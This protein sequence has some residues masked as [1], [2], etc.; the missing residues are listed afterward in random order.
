[1]LP[2]CVLGHRRHID[3]ERQWINP[4][5][6][7]EPTPH[8]LGLTDGS[9]F[10]HVSFPKS[11]YTIYNPQSRTPHFP[12]PPPSLFPSSNLFIFHT[13]PLLKKTSLRPFHFRLSLETQRKEKP[14][15]KNLSRWIRAFLFWVVV[16]SWIWKSEQWYESHTVTRRHGT[17]SG[18]SD[19]GTQRFKR[20]TQ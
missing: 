7:A 17:R 1:M 4:K 15:L 14:S 9:T 6:G 13:L 3:R 18:D 8:S 16:I 11:D 12:F 5:G 2:S 10:V 20:R 19:D